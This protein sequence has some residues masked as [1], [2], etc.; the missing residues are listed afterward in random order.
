MF[1]V[2]DD[3]HAVHENVFH[4]GRILMGFFKR[5]V[6]CDRRRI[7]YDHIGEHSLLEKSAMIETEV[8]CGQAAQPMNRIGHRKNL[9]VAGIFA[10]RARKVPIRARMRI[11]FQ[12]NAFGR[13]RRFVR[14]ERDPWLSELFLHVRFGHEGIDR[15]DA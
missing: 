8:G 1:S 13:L 4:A 6:V 15:A 7:E 5:G 11:G 9:F 2:L 14:A 12:E 10:E 3:L